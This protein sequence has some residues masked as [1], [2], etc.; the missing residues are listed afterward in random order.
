MTPATAAFKAQS[1]NELSFVELLRLA[2]KKLAL[3]KGRGPEQRL[4]LSEDPA[5]L[6]SRLKALK[7]NFET[8]LP[9]LRS[10][11]FITGGPYPYSSEIVQALD[12]LQQANA[13][14]RENPSYLRFSP[15]IFADTS[16]VVEADIAQIFESS[17][18]SL[19]AFGE[20]VK[21][22][23]PLILDPPTH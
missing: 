2:I 13:I 9:P 3:D 21:G 19:A 23:E 15:K 17:Q 10:I 18:E 8:K 20:F 5:D 4:W 1:L 6:Q 16:E 7:D 11:S 22:L 14:A 12:L